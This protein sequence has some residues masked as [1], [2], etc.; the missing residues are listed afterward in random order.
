M[1]NLSMV[2]V[3]YWLEEAQ[4]CE[5][6]QRM[7]LVQRN[8]YPFL[9]NYFEGIE[10]I[11]ASHPYVS[12]AQRMAIINEFFPNTNSL[13]SEIM[14]QNPDIVVEATKPAAEDD[15]PLMK[16]ALTYFFDKA[17][18]L[19]ENRVALF[20]MLYAGYCAVEVDHIV[21]KQQG[22]PEFPTGS[23]GQKQNVFQKVVS[24]FKKAVNAEQAEEN[25]EKQAPASEMPYATNEMTYIR[26]WDP[27]DVPL[28]WRANRLKDRR[29]NLRK[30][31]MSKAELD[32]AYPKFKNRVMAQD[33]SFEFAKHNLMQHSRKVLLYEFQVRKK[34]NKYQTILISPSIN[35]EE[36]DTFER[37]YTTNGF[38][39]K[40][41][42]L[43]KYG[44]LYPI[45]YAQVNRKMQDEM[46]HYVRFM[47]EVAERNIPKRMADKNKVKT[48]AQTALNS[49]KVNDLALLDGNISGAIAEV[50]HTNV[51]VENKELLSIFQDQKNKLWAVSEAKIAGKAQVKFAT[52]LAIQEAGFES[53][54][55]DIQEGLRFLIQEE[56]DAGKDLIV[57]F[58]D[59]EVFLKITG[60]EKMDWYEP[61][62]G[63]DPNNPKQQIVLNP[64]SDLLTG[65][66]LVKVDI[67]SALRPNKEKKL[68]DMF[69]FM[70]Q[71]IQLRDLLQSQ[72]KD[73]NVEEIRRISKEFGWNPEKLLIDFQPPQPEGA[74][75]EMSPEEDARR[76]EEAQ[77]RIAAL[78]GKT[79]LPAR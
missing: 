7:E 5:Y 24:T 61:I 10:K 29:Y 28:D 12:T 26:R 53:R 9:V 65:D 8:N 1:A 75:G 70:G 69:T 57:S 60:S 44:K 23:L 50:P 36:I 17:D 48:D 79:P 37:P 78:E 66:Y 25:V 72:G 19:I 38:N 6:R 63:A 31:W 18:G 58:W 34:E 27:L 74:E 55:L 59:N 15:T 33:E 71:L 42:T 4:S 2:E 52:E 45:A 22:Q 14:Y 73:V 41:G 62:V 16:A 3:K 32:V 35:N 67:S 20:D 11:D 13:I 51:S 21:P 77:R 64:L 68:N 40:I 39:M 46:N 76:E 56:L 54:Q 49:N 47:M 43:H 30:V